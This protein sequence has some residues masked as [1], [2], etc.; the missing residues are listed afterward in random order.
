MKSIDLH[1]YS[2]PEC[3]A[4]SQGAQV[5]ITDAG[6]PVAIVYGLQGLDDEQL[7]HCRDASFWD[8]MLARR[9]QPT[10]TRQELEQ[11]LADPQS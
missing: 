11:S 7:Q 10:L 9:E 3:V 1:S 2:L 8:L 4:D 5:L 6:R